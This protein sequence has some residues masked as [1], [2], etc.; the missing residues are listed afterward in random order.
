MPS[1][2]AH[3]G[4]NGQAG[5]ALMETVWRR[6]KDHLEDERR[7]IYEEIKNYPTPIAG[8]DAQFNHL[9]EKRDR[10]AHELNRLEASARESLTRRER[11]KCIDEFIMS[12]EYID[13]EMKQGIRT[14]L[15]GVSGGDAADAQSR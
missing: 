4:M 5:L 11:V 12:S 14:S 6:I 15:L 10:I 13:G 2:E 3:D 9:L 8:C 1:E 7:R